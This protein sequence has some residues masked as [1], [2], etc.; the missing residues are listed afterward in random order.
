MRKIILASMAL[1]ALT[2]CPA[3]QNVAQSVNTQIASICAKAAPLAG[4][5][6][7]V[8]VYLTAACADEASIAKVAL[9]PT[10]L[11]WISML[12]GQLQ[13]I[14]NPPAKV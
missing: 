13:A 10:G 11:S 1:V 7:P 8:G 14:I 3:A 6:P 2:G 12:W 4:A 5:Y 9:S